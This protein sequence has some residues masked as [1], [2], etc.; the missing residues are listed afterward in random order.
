MSA[1]AL[2]DVEREPSRRFATF[3]MG[4]EETS[5]DERPYARV[6]AERFRTDHHQLVFTPDDAC[7]EIPLLG[8]LMD[9]PLGDPSFLP[10]VC[11]AVTR[12]VR[13]RLAGKKDHQR[14]LWTLMAFELW[15]E[16][17]VPHDSWA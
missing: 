2:W 8:Q 6:V 12:L 11:L 4:F 1:L 9:E 17:Y 5:Y 14:A 16:A 7:A 15:R 3:P 13:E 10:T